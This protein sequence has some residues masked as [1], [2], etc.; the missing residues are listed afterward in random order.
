MI[1]INDD[2]FDLKNKDSLKHE[3][4]VEKTF[5]CDIIKKIRIENIKEVK[6]NNKNY[7]VILKSFRQQLLSLIDNDNEF[8]TEYSK[9]VINNGKLKIL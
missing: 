7:E 9:Y 6:E 3:E 5:I 2:F 8:E 1:T 4:I